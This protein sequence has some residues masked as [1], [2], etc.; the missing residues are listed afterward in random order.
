MMNSYQGTGVSTGIGIG[1]AVVLNESG[2]DYSH[3]P[4]SGAETEKERLY[5]GVERFRLQTS[6][7]AED[8]EARAGEKQAQILLGQ[9]MM[10]NDPFMLSQIHERIEEKGQCAEAAL[11]A[12]CGLYIDM[13]SSVDDELTRERAADVRDLRERML[14]ILLGVKEADIGAIP[15]GTVLIAGEITPSMASAVNAEHLAG[16]AAETGGATSHL[17]ILARAMRVPTV[18]SVE[19][20]RALVQN[21]DIVIVDGTDGK[22]IVNPDDRTLSLYRA[23]REAAERERTL[24]EKYKARPTVTA[25]GRKAAIYANIG[26]AVEAGAALDA[27][28]EGVGLFRTEFLFMDRSGPPSENEQ[29]EAYKEAAKSLNGRKLIIRT[30]DVGGDKDVPYLKLAREENPFLGYRAI[31]YC[32]DRED[33]FM[34]QLRAILRSSAHGSVNIMLPLIT[35]PDEIRQAKAVISR[36]KDELYEKGEPFNPDIPVGVMIETPAAAVMADVLAKEADF[37]SIGT[38]DLTQYVM[39]ADRGNGKVA[40]LNSPL[41]PAVLRSIKRVIGCAKA[42]DIPV[43]MCGEA[44]ANPL[45]IPLLLSFGLEEFS[46]GASSV[47]AV[48]RLISNWT[49]KE[50]DRLAGEVMK[51]SSAEGIRAYLSANVKV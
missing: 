9:I 19:N 23:R 25:D 7:M 29:Y 32:L 31:R 34:P 12:V 5:S 33:I 45:M 48:R 10:I 11:D 15:P 8:M 20:A 14:K 35:C 21:G 6:Q 26:T 44:A 40:Y 4:F 24:L 41:N 18:L 2:L 50:A 17:S 30:L 46:V 3:V 39:A 28:A 22:L 49:K 16:M 42:E 1:K 27:G 47:L 51:L 36:V 37:F 38:N 43:G 13:F